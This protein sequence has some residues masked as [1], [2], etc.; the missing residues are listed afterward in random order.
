MQAG[1]ASDPAAA[2]LTARENDRRVTVTYEALPNLDT[3]ERIRD[4]LVG[5]LPLRLLSWKPITRTVRTIESLHV[6]FKAYKTVAAQQRASFDILDSSRPYLHLLF[7][8]CEDSDVYRATTRQQIRLWLDSIAARQH[9]VNVEWLIVHVTSSKTSGSSAK[10]Y[11]RKSTISDKIRADFNTP[12]RDRCISLNT[13]VGTDSIAGWLE[14]LQKMKEGIVLSFE[15][16]VVAYEE[17]LRK[18]DSQR[19]LPGWNFCTF[20]IQKVAI[21]FNA[22]KNPSKLRYRKDS[23]FLLKQ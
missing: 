7:V 12:K 4:D 23:R 21:R 17:D 11:Q 20:F 15:A 18:L 14:L 1:N 19:T 8:N 6:D 9:T 16:N 22:R 3:F 5:R 2:E 10:F 13:D